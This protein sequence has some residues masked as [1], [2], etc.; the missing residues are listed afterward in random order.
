[1]IDVLRFA[2]GPVPVCPRDVCPDPFCS[3]ER[4]PAPALTLEQRDAAAAI[5]ARPLVADRAHDGETDG[6]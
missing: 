1:M 2:G 4:P 5:I 6:R 3:C